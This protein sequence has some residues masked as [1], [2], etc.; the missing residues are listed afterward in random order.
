[1]SLGAKGKI[2]TNGLVMLLDAANPKSFQ[3]EPTTN[4]IN[5]ATDSYPRVGN[6]WGT[7]NTNQ[8]NNG[9]YF[10]IGTVSAVT[11]NEVTMSAAHPLR[12]YDVVRPQ[13]SGG[14]L[15]AG[16]DYYIKK[17]SSTTFTVHQYDYTQD[18][19]KGFEV[20]RPIRND[21]R[22]SINST[23]FPTM[24]WG[25]PHLPNS[26]LIKTI[27]PNAFN[28]HECL[29]LNWY[30][31]DGVVDG[32][33]YGVTP[34]VVSGSSYTYSWYHRAANSTAES[35][36]GYTTIYYTGNTSSDT[37]GYYYPKQG[38][39]RFS[40]TL[41]AP[42]NGAIYL[43]WWPSAASMSVDISEIQIESKSYA[44]AYTPTTR[45][46]TWTDSSW[47]GNNGTLV[48]GPTYN[49]AGRGSVYTDGSSTYINASPTIGTEMTIGF[50]I[51]ASNYNGKIPIS[52]DGTNYSSGPNIYFTGNI[53]AW[54]TGDG[55]TNAFANSSYPSTNAWHFVVVTNSSSANTAKLYIDGAYV[56]AASYLN[57]TASGTNSLWIGRF[58]GD[59]NYNINAYFGVI[60]LYNR[61]LTA[62]EISDFY[63]STLPRYT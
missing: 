12:T 11:N 40:A 13:T 27:I 3:G 24:W 37:I 7:Y 55:G 48:N 53:I 56:G 60:Y 2:P 17:T 5:S 29:R 45:G 59:T 42:A 38:W 58:H 50:W 46:T 16:T 51:N 4:I 52:I 23:S 61:A 21:T 20:L 39:R 43:Y 28:G 47:N 54:N 32:M 6:G 9:T 26:G 36:Y 62:T 31:P 15:S 30:R 22:I 1:M 25:Y 34:T 10:S 44:T 49:T 63:K 18:G 33:A 8:Y 41:T 57:T 14:G 35:S 19:S